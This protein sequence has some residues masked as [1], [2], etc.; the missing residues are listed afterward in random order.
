MSKIWRQSDNLEK[1]GAIWK[2]CQNLK[3][4]PKFV[5]A[6]LKKKTFYFIKARSDL[7]HPARL[8]VNPMCIQG[9]DSID[10]F[11]A[12]VYLFENLEKSLY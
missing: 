9:E 6:K 1:F 3:K 5:K 10:I 8:H 7:Y 2:N 4:I 12:E 11:Q